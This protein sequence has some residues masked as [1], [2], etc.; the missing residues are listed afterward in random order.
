MKVILVDDEPLALEVLKKELE[1]FSQIQVEGAFT[2]AYE[3]LGFLREHRV[4]AVFLDIELGSVNGIEIAHDFIREL[5]GLEIVFVSAY[6]QYAVEAFEINA[7][8][9]L[10]K[11]VQK[12][13][14]AESVKRL[15]LS[16]RL[17]SVKATY[18]RLEVRSFGKFE[19]FDS[20]GE[21][22]S[23]R[24]QKAREVFAF[25]WLKQGRWVSKSV[26]MD[27]VFYD[28]DVQRATTLLH[29]TIYQLRKALGLAGIEEA[30]SFKNGS[31]KLELFLESDKKVIDELVKRSEP[32]GFEIS[33]L[34]ELYK[35]DFFGEE[36]YSWVMDL[37]ARYREA[38]YDSLEAFARKLIE[39]DKLD[40]A[41]PL[42][43]KLL[44][45]DPF[46][47]CGVE[48][49]I[50]YYGKRGLSG[51]LSSFYLNYR[52]SLAREMGLRPMDSTRELYHFYTNLS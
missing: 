3:A 25:L 26:L 41:Y 48:H 36:G 52:E 49:M 8:D 46:R 22:L 31:Y 21:A 30:I 51:K 35:G 2:D 18:K 19:V 16:P 7:L 28:R 5:P 1:E 10:L 9:Y 33:R 27:T 23:W 24:T 29:T 34:L 11:P 44:F 15:S 13:R 40:E 42:I 37:Q 20:R 38:V 43:E 45:I 14:L 4:G 12:K 17:G 50:S 39:G 6:S 47:E 32:S